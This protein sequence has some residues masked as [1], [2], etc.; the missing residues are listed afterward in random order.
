MWKYILKR[1]LYVI[2]VVLFCTLVVFL[3]MNIKPGDPGRIVLGFEATQ[4]AVDAY[5]HAIGF[6]RP[7]LVRYVD[8]VFNLLKGDWGTSYIGGKAI[9]PQIKEFFPNTLKLS[10]LALICSFIVGVPLGVLSAVK[11]YSLADRM[12]S[13]TAMLLA[14]IPS[15]WLCLLMMML[16]SVKLKWLPSFGLDDWKSYILPVI[17]LSANSIG[18]NIRLTR[19]TMLEEIRKD[20]VRTARSKGAKERTVIYSHA[21]MNSLIPVVTSLGYKFT[22]QIGGAVFVESVFAIPGIGSLVIKGINNNDTPLVVG[23]VV[24]ISICSVLINLLVDIVYAFLDP[25]IKGKYISSG[26]KKKKTKSGVQEA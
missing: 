18:T 12:S 16:F 10:V 20:Y 7:V 24:V 4:E 5:N 17:A 14:C 6:D 2:P 11:Q 15:F 21:L 3:I 9:W 19:S 26:K 13:V 8:Y 23:C 1:L 22:M 25:R